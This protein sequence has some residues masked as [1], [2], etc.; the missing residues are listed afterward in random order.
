MEATGV[1]TYNAKFSFDMNTGLFHGKAYT[2]PAYKYAK[3]EDP[4]L[5]VDYIESS[6]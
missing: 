1:S 2:T 3:D 4:F 6:V 5:Q